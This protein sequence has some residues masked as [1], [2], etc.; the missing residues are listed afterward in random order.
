MVGRRRP[1]RGIDQQEDHVGLLDGQP[2]LLLDALLDGVA[3]VLLEAAGVDDDEAPAVP[4][5]HVVQPVARRSRAI[6]DDRH[7]L[8]DDAVEERALA[9]VRPA[10]DGD[11]RQALERL[12]GQPAAGRA[13]AAPRR[14]VRPRRRSASGA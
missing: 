13:A 14:H 10:D 8:A 6:L 2:G 11:H 4:L 12:V 3:R 9:D 5:G 1:G 7:A